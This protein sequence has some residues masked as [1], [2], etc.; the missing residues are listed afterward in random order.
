MKDIFAYAD[1]IAVCVYSIGELNRAIKII[2]EW[3]NKTRI[4]I[5]LRKS[6][7]LNIR[8]SNKTSKIV[9][10][11]EYMNYPIVEKYKYLGVWIDEKLN[12]DTHL[13]SY[14]PKINYLINRFKIIP[15]NSITPR[16]LINL[17]TL[18]IRPIYDYAFCIAKLRNKTDEKQYMVAELQSF[19]KLMSL[20]NT[21]SN[22]LIKDL[23]GYDP[24]KLASKIIRLAELRWNERNGIVYQ[25]ENMEI[26]YRRKTSNLLVTWNML[27][28]NNS[29]FSK[30]KTH[31]TVIT[32]AH[33][34]LLHGGEN[35]TSL[36][37]IL[38]EG[39]EV[40]D[41]IKKNKSERRGRILKILENR[42]NTQDLIAKRILNTLESN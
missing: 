2:E 41:K 29:F 16:Y 9:L 1:D 35:M 8:K 37:E 18:I 13:E 10:G 4:P 32:P 22:E 24:D 7:I 30:C 40:N 34:R 42:I 20:R 12:P 39:Y 28:C 17:W 11:S 14:K 26:N 33:I 36:S 6:G 3:S 23:I 19:K 38:K 21:T 5:N 25:E 31:N 27:W 15:K